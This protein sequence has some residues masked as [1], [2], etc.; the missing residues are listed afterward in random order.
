M[1]KFVKHPIKANTVPLIQKR[2][3]TPEDFGRLL[4]QIKQLRGYSISACEVPDEIAV[5]FAIGDDIYTA[6]LDG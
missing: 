3:F 1:R 2:I 5:E 6:I 4:R